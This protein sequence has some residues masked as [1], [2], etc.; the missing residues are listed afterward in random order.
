MPASRSTRPRRRFLPADEAAARTVRRARRLSHRTR[1]WYPG[2]SQGEV[3]ENNAFFAEIARRARTP[4]PPPLETTGLDTTGWGAGNNS[5]RSPSPPPMRSKTFGEGWETAGWG[6]DND[7]PSTLADWETAGWSL[8]D[9][10]SDF[11][12][13]IVARREAWEE[14]QA[15]ENGAPI[16]GAST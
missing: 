8:A 1:L 13:G 12:A 7:P 3:D 6:G 11:L 4:S 5:A 16:A 15:S 2:I 9:F 14:A 10:S